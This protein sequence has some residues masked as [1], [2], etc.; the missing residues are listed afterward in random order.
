MKKAFVFIYFLLIVLDFVFNSLQLKW[1]FLITKNAIPL[2]LI[3]SFANSKNYSL[4]KNDFLL[5][6]ALILLS[7]GLNFSY[8]F[9]TEAIYLPVIT[10]IYFF[11]IQIHLYL[12]LKKLK[13]I[14]TKRTKVFTKTFLIF[15]LGLFFI[16]V[17]FPFFSFNLQ[18]LF[19]I[20]VFQYAYFISLVF[21]NKKIN[22]QISLSLW[23]IILSNVALLAD[24]VIF[25]YD[26]EYIIIMLFFYSSKFFFVNGY[27]NFNKPLRL[28]GGEISSIKI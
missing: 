4:N 15:S 22:P 7:I 2:F 24:L 23:F 14:E 11:E 16:I 18:I 26:F 1:Y 9:H 28:N 13:R 8:F 5:I 12:I 3:F 6:A 19:F 27:L 21:G 17:F 10:I 20:R 25:K